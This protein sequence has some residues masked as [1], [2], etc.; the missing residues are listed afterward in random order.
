M[1]NK[2]QL[3]SLKKFLITALPLLVLLH[4]Q[5]GPQDNWYITDRVAMPSGCSPYDLLVTPDGKILLADTGNDK[6]HELQA[7]GTLIRS[8]GS[9]GS[10]NGQFNNPVELAVGPN[11]RIYVSD[12][13][14]N[15]IQILERD[16][17]F[18]KAFGSNGTGDG[19]FSKPRGIAISSDNEVFVSEDGNHRIQ[20]FDSNGN[21][22]RKWGTQGNLDGQL[23]RPLSI[24]LDEADELYVAEYDNS[25]ISIFSTDGE[26]IRKFGVDRHTSGGYP[27]IANIS[28]T[29]SGIILTGGES[30]T[31]GTNVRYKNVLRLREK[32]GA[33]IDFVEFSHNNVYG[34]W[35]PSAQLDNGTIIFAHRSAN[36][37]V[38][39]TNTYRT[40][41]H[42]S[43]K[44]VP[45]VDVVSVKQPGGTNYLEI[46]YRIT[47][48]D[49]SSVKVGLLAFVDGGNDLTKVIVPSTFV[50][51]TAGKLGAN[52]ATDTV[53]TL[54][55]DAKA[56]WD[57]L[58]GNIEL[59]VVAQDDRELMN[60]HFLT[61]PAT[62]TNSTQLKINRSPVGNNDF[63]EAWYTLLALGESEILL[64]S[65]TIKH[66]TS[67]VT[68]ASGSSTTAAGRAY[69]FGK[70]DLREATSTEIDRAKTASTPGIVNKFTPALQVGPGIRPVKVNEFS[71]DTEGTGY[72]VVDPTP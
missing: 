23:N 54:T 8:F 55:W 15:R 38:F 40:I 26:F 72:W 36:Q 29:T 16:G 46:K 28:I 48:A 32:N 9:R 39:L 64:D 1:K 12:L 33:L 57:V 49:S 3:Y 24:D 42:N 60:F 2:V 25:R 47:D 62:D 37:L 66:A 70:M 27:R 69:L 41:R 21:F 45:L 61:L 17:T 6:I 63:K 30:E 31:H 71:F 14:N 59:A 51:F 58:F 50:G 53:H 65:G 4:A 10:G 44:N 35:S 43:S 7:D 22:L 52:V 18:V 56:D 13:D 5:R 11:N 68:F 34:S 20:V 67:G 19:Q